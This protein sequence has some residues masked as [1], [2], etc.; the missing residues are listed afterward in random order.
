MI[1]SIK[2]MWCNPNGAHT[3]KR[4]QSFQKTKNQPGFFKNPWPGK[5]LEDTSENAAPLHHFDTILNNFNILMVVQS[6]VQEWCRGAIR[7]ALSRVVKTAAPRPMLYKIQLVT[8]MV[9]VVQLK[10]S[11]QTISSM[12]F[13]GSRVQPWG[14]MMPGAGPQATG[15]RPIKPFVW[16]NLFSGDH[17]RSA[18]LNGPLSRARGSL[19]S[20]MIHV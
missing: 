20:N 14:A 9:Q 11:L 16:P 13:R 15:R 18:K 2:N 8:S 1:T 19:L 4:I 10:M 6:V 3:Q 7:G 12:V 5:F 17:A